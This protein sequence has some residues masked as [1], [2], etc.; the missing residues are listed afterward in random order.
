MHADP[1]T[2]CFYARR[3]L[4]LAVAWVYKH[5]AALQL[6][7]QDNLRA[8]IHEP[9]LQAGRG[10]GGVQQ[11]AGH[12]SRSATAP[13]TAIAPIQP[14]RRAGRRARAVPRLLLARAHLRPRGAAGARARVRRRARCRRPR[15]VA[16]ADRRAA[17]AARSAS[18]ASGT[19][20]SRRCWP[21]RPRSTRSWSGCAPRSPRRR[22]RAAAQ[23]DTHDYSEAE[24]R[25]YFIDLLLKEAGW[26]LDQPRDREFEVSGHAERRRARASSTTCCG[27][28]TASRSA[29]SRRSARGATPRVGQQQAKLYADCLEQQFGQRPV[30]FY[31]NGY[32]HWIWDDASYPPRAVQGFYKKDELELLIQR[33]TT[34]QA[35]RRRG[36]STRRSSSGTTRRA[37]SAASRE[38]FETRP[39]AQGAARDGDRRGQDAH[40]HRAVRPADALQLGQARAVPRRPRRAG[41][42]GG[43]RVQDAPARRVAGQPRHREGRPRAASSS[44]P[45]RR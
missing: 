20:S 6:P 18:C 42:P 28:T 37:R 27:A 41:E 30:I 23:P 31:S 17:A 24:T 36:R 8:L 12:Q 3:A 21:T 29:W 39:R 11:G 32:E 22:R 2:A 25:D 14:D 33:R 9:T 7:Y 43:Q 40:G 44:R 4:E 45:I 34:P 10:R 13:S 38:A 26:P 1:R 35:A 16:E 15:R 19:R 5:D